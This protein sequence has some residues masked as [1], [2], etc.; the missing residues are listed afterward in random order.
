MNKYLVFSPPFRTHSS[1]VRGSS[2]K[3]QQ[4]MQ[5]CRNSTLYDNLSMFLHPHRPMMECQ[6]K[7]GKYGVYST[8][9]LRILWAQFILIVSFTVTYY[10]SRLTSS[11]CYDRRYGRKKND[12][13]HFGKCFVSLRRLKHKRICIK[14]SRAWTNCI[15]IYIQAWR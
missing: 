5:Y 7:L 15:E 14:K 13:F 6:Y 8:N 9:E 2:K 4:R 10:T 11:N 1:L 3:I 12:R